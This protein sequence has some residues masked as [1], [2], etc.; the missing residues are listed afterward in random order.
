MY[1][2]SI[3]SVILMQRIHPHFYIA[4]LTDISISCVRKCTLAEMLGQEAVREDSSKIAGIPRGCAW[5]HNHNTWDCEKSVTR[6]G[7]LRSDKKENRNGRQGGLTEDQS[8]TQIF[9][10]L[11]FNI[12]IPD[13][14]LRNTIWIH[15]KSMASLSSIFFLF[16]FF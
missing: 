16:S 11:A 6:L 12:K 9:L 15:L 8:L 10:L 13:I 7:A 14:L 5:G 2:S 1:D 3:S 4:H